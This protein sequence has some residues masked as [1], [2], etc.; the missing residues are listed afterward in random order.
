[1]LDYKELEDISNLKRISLINTEKDYLQELILF[2][3][4]SK[5]S[6]ELIFKGGTCLY[7]AYKLNRFSEDLDFTLQKDINIKKTID[8]IIK[9]M[10]L[11]NINGAIKEL[12]IYKNDINVRLL[13]KGPLFKGNKDSQCFIPLN[14]SKKEKS[15]LEPIKK[16]ISSM[17]KEIPNFDVF[18][19]QEKEILAEKVRAILTREKP[20]DIY[21]LWFLLNNNVEIN[22]E[23][24]DKKLK[25]YGLKFNINNFKN[26]IYKKKNLWNLDLKN[27]I[28]S[29]LPEFDLVVNTILS[30]IKIVNGS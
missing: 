17:Y 5:I 28:I 24:I 4:Y 20:R 22:F 2:S 27:L 21:D 14:I 3:L 7:K 11:F 8:K 23:L 10:R 16:N 19:M 30:N 13:F 18:V 25:L 29:D 26:A 1:M 15:I 9:D 6:D 12:K